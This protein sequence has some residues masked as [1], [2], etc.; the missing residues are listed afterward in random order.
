MEV[1]RE[2]VVTILGHRELVVVARTA[3]R[4]RVAAAD[5][6]GLIGALS[7][8]EYEVV[9]PYT[10]DE[11]VEELELRAATVGRLSIELTRPGEFARFDLF[12]L[13]TIF[14]QP[15][16]GTSRQG[17]TYDIEVLVVDFENFHLHLGYI[18]RNRVG[19]GGG[20][21]ELGSTYAVGA[22]YHTVRTRFDA[23]GIGGVERHGFVAVYKVETYHGVGLFDYARPGVDTIRNLLHGYLVGKGATGQVYLTEL[24]YVGEL[25]RSLGQ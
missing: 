4:N 3:V 14:G 5:F 24:G 20:D 22:I 1:D 9:F 2:F 19:R 13:H 8:I 18:N 16:T 21:L 15:A 23:A 6:D 10:G 12:H 17:A 25:L 11:L 7:R